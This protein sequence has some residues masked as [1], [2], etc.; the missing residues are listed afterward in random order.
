MSGSTPHAALAEALARAETAL[1]AGDVA[2]AAREMA[3]AADLCR[4]LQAAGLPVPAEHAESLG[5]LSARCG[6][7][8]D[9][10]ASELQV[11]SRRNEQ[12]RRGIV[13]Y[14]GSRVR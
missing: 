13:S 8:L 7:H 14:T 2:A 5:A 1:A 3:E 4:R 9:R 10:L 6:E 11:D 12:H